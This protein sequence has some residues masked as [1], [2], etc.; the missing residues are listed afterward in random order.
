VA[1]IALA[2]LGVA[3][4]A[5]LHSPKVRARQTAELAAEGLPGSASAPLTVHLPLAGD[6]GVAQALD[7]IAG[8]GADARVLLVGHEPDLSGLVSGLTGGRVELK[9]GGLAVVRLQGAS[10]ELVVLMRPGELALIA[11]G[12]V[13]VGGE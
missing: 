13:P 4:E 2:R 12:G 10:A 7:A 6:F 3:F 9:K 11:C 8:L 5:I 1:G